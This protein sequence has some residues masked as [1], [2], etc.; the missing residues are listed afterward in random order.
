M[1]PRGA[2]RHTQAV[3]ARSD[4][5]SALRIS[6]LAVAPSAP[7]AP[8]LR[9]HPAQLCSSG[10]S[11][12]FSARHPARLQ[13]VTAGGASQS[14]RLAAAPVA[15]LARQHTGQPVQGRGQYES[16]KEGNLDDKNNHGKPPVRF[17]AYFSAYGDR[18]PL[19]P[20]ATSTARELSH[21]DKQCVGLTANGCP[22][23]PP[24][25]RDDSVRGRPLQVE[26]TWKAGRSAG[27][28]RAMS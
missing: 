13:P 3:G 19:L 7:E 6:S 28:G 16:H 5:R 12:E 24:G 1:L 20:P 26:I 9:L 10:I 14:T 25:G 2:L 23:T 4:P 8:A 15:T 18:A 17:L 27:E 21:Q 22:Q 11:G